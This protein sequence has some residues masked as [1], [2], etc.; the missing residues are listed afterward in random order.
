MDEPDTILN[1]KQ[2]DSK[3]AHNCAM[4]LDFPAQSVE[5][6]GTTLVTTMLV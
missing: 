4:R 1:N 6:I 3:Y 5:N 2:E